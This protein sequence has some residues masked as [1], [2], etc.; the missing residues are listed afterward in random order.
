MTHSIPL[1]DDCLS[2]R[3]AAL[4]ATNISSLRQ[5]I[6]LLEQIDDT[7]YT[8]PPPG[9]P[10]HRVGS[11]IRHVLEFYE[12]FL[13]GMED[14]HVDYDSRRRDASVESG[15]MA[16]ITKIHSIIHRLSGREILNDSLIWIRMEDS[17]GFSGDRYLTSSSARELQ[18]LGSHT[19]HHF[20]LIGLTLA[21]HGIEVGSDFGMAPS[22]LRYMASLKSKA[23]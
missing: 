12:C 18:I 22:T 17:D 19:V 16:A 9:L 15:R 11:H 14:S 10:R 6:T 20:A 2:R 5:A 21:A 13:D 8:E 3:Q 23:A 1:Q 7:A 4:V